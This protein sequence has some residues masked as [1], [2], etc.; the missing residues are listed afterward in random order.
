MAPVSH[1]FS[2]C[3][4]S[5]H[6]AYARLGDLC[7]AHHA[8]RL[9]SSTL[10]DEAPMSSGKEAELKAVSPAKD[11]EPPLLPPQVCMQWRLCPVMRD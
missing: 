8:E 1:E 7:L 10:A 3:L 11:E 9:L 6:W 5:Q 2:A 4:S